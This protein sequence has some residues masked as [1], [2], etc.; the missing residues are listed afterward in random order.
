MRNRVVVIALVGM[1]LGA[2][3]VAFAFWGAAGTGSG[4]GGAVTPAAL[5]LS[6]GT[7]TTSVYPGGQGS[8]AL[9]VTNPNTFIVHIT[10]IALD[11]ARGTAGF[12]VDGGHSGCATSTLSFTTQ[13]NGATGWDAPAKVGGTNGSL[14]VTLS[15]AI[16]M[17]VAAANA[18][19]GAAITVYLAVDP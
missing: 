7:P 14:T 12:A 11:T 5:T 16:A 3:G 1:A 15:S 10:S 4:S 2:S 8:V 19:Q 18:C 6:A 13:T 17:S 9:T